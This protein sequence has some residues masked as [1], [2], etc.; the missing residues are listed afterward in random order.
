M[1]NCFRY[2]HPAMCGSAIRKAFNA[3]LDGVWPYNGSEY[4]R[5]RTGAQRHRL[6]SRGHGVADPRVCV[7][8]TPRRGVSA[9]R[10]IG[11]AA[12]RG[13]LIAF[14][15]HDDSWPMGRHEVML[16]VLIENPAVDA[17][18]GRMRIRFEP[19][20]VPSAAYLA[21]DGKFPQAGSVCCGL[22]RRRILDRIGGFAEDMRFGED[23]DYNMRLIE[24]GI[25]IELCEID[26]LVYRRHGSNMTNDKKALRDGFFDMVRRKLARARRHAAHGI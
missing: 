16:R 14:L 10:N 15:D 12:A 17:V 6:H 20:T 9:A 11:L 19:Q 23:A 21:A 3:L 4:Q 13:D 18:L 8:S 25:R 5:D 22:Y 7:L 2:S 26:S 24:A 1:I